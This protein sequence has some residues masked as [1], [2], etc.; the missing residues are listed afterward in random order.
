[1]G[2]HVPTTHS[3]REG[4]LSQ[5]INGE[6]VLS[7][8]KNGDNHFFFPNGCGVPFIL[9]FGVPILFPMCSPLT[10]SQMFPM[11]F[12]TLPPPPPQVLIVFL[13]TF[14]TSSPSYQFVSSRCSQLHHTLSHNFCPKLN[15][16]CYRVEPKG[17]HSFTIVLGEC[18]KRIENINN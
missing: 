4:V 12:S 15:L 2:A 7:Q 18:V 10:S 16:H 3:L 8:A 14:Q 1:M 13:K 17:K 6:G 11:I 5:A 9:D